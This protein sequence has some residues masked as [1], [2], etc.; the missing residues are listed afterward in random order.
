[1]VESKL[2]EHKTSP[3]EIWMDEGLHMLM[4]GMT[5]GKAAVLWLLKCAQSNKVTIPGS[6]SEGSYGTFYRGSKNLLPEKHIQ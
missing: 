3:V 1:M 6:N 4:L 5:K 2:Q